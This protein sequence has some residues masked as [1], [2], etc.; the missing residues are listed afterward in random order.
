VG[1]AEFAPGC[2]P[3]SDRFFINDPTGRFR[4]YDERSATVEPKIGRLVSVRAPL[5]VKAVVSTPCSR[6]LP[7]QEPVTL[8]VL[9]DASQ[10]CQ[11]SLTATTWLKRPGVLRV[12]VRGAPFEDHAAVVGGR[13]HAIRAGALTEIRVPIGSGRADVS[14]DFDW[15][16]RG[17]LLPLVTRVVLDQDGARDS[18]L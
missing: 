18:L 10:P 8:R 9:A 11:P 7:V 14:V 13:R 15:A 12:T 2:A 5:R 4:F 3:L 1:E 16:A 17:P 6:A